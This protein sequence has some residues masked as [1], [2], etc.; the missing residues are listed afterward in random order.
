MARFVPTLAVSM[1][2]KVIEKHITDDRS[3]KG[4]DHYSALN[5]DEFKS[6]VRLIRCL[7]DIIGEVKEWNLSEAEKKY[8]IFAKRQAVVSREIA[9]GTKLNFK[10]IVFKR[11]NEKGL[12]HK[13]LEK[14]IGRKITRPKN[15]D[16]PL[17]LEDFAGS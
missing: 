4:R 15:T 6:F 14:Y 11:T 16:D 17:T 7:P 12:S 8:R 13:D 2:A 1:G 5:P 10:D 9:V 3:R